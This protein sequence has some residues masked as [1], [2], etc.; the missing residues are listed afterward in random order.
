MR[1]YETTKDRCERVSREHKANLLGTKGVYDVK[2]IIKGDGTNLRPKIHSKE[3]HLPLRMTDHCE[4]SRIQDAVA[5]RASVS[6]RE[7]FDLLKFENPEWKTV[8]KK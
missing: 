8:D 2:K 1:T 6:L 5:E 4:H 3:K 7:S